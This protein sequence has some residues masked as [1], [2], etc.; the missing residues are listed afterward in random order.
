MIKSKPRRVVFLIFLFGLSIYVAS[1]FLV[2]SS[3]AVDVAIDYA[4]K[5]NLISSNARVGFTGFKIR[6]TG[7]EGNAS[8]RLVDG[9]HR[10]VSFQLVRRAGEWE[11]ALANPDRMNHP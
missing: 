9:S 8:F 2:A 10:E 5:R 3:D 7:Q 1:Y 4:V 6:V 11:V